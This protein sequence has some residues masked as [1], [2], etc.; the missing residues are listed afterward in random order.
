MNIQRTHPLLQPTRKQLPPKPPSREEENWS[1][2]DLATSSLS[3]GGGVLGLAGGITGNPLMI[4]AGAGALAAG[5]AL[6]AQRVSTQGSLDSQFALNVGVGSGLLLGG[7][8]LLALTP[9]PQSLTP[10]QQ[11]LQ[12][13]PAASH[14]F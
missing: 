8:G 10:L 7:L 3:L 6:E 1:L 12:Q 13:N 5:S 4:A 14:L 9:P 11:W 2:R